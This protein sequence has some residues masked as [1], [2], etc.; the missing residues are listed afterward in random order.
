MSIT[1][2]HLLDLYRA[3]QHGEPAPP[4]PGTHDRQVVREWREE[5]RFRAVLSGR[6]AHG[7]TRI[8]LALSRW[9][10]PRRGFTT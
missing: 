2:Q 5:R 1:Q 3:Q 10:R 7:R 8:R 6:P 9:L 4:A